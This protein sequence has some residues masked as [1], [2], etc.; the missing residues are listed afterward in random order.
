MRSA[1]QAGLPPVLQGVYAT[2]GTLQ[3]WRAALR[4]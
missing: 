3:V 4:G 1:A 2:L